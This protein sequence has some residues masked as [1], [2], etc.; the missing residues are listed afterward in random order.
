MKEPSNNPTIENESETEKN[1]FECCVCE[2]RETYDYK[3]RK[4]PFVRLIK[5]K[6][7]SYIK[8]DPF[9]PKKKE[10]FLIL[11]SDCSSCNKPVCQ[12][13][14]CSF[15]YK[16]TYC[17]LC[18]KENAERFPEDVQSRLKRKLLEKT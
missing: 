4:P 17:S 5:F 14:T 6:E 18:A 10:L 12:H 9:S 13:S 1:C 15:F 8:R 11:G 2:L 16:K 3:G 7:D